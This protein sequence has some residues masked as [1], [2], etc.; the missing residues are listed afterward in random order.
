MKKKIS[1]IG[2]GITGIYC[3]ILLSNSGHNVEV[4]EANDHPG[5]ILRDI[6]F[7][8]DVFFKACQLLDSETKWFKELK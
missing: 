4:Y 3:A 8:N 5:G 6:H 7:N 2:A 1:I